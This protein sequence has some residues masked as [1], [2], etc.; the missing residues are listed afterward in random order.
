LLSVVSI[1]A[2][3]APERE[4]IRPTLVATARAATVTDEEPAAELAARQF[5]PKPDEARLGQAQAMLDQA[6]GRGQ[7]TRRDE[8]LLRQLRLEA[9]DTDWVPFMQR[10]GAALNDGKLRPPPMESD[11]EP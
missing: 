10:L 11:G 1:P 9:P 7:W 5:R 6:T 8:D 2:P 4:G 3:S